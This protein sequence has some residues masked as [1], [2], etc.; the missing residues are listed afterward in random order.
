[1]RRN[2]SIAVLPETP[3]CARGKLKSRGGG[4]QAATFV[5]S[6]YPER[7]EGS[8]AAQLSARRSFVHLAYAAKHEHRCATGDPSLRSGSTEI[9]WWWSSG[10]HVRDLSLS[11]AQ[12]G[13]SGGT[14]KRAPLICVP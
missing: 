4:L 13:I 14:A 3:R 7:S 11:R 10:R 6:V 2:T 1:M 9:T 12:R 5:T 8:P